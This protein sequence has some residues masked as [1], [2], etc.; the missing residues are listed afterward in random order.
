MMFLHPTLRAFPKRSENPY[1]A[2][3][4]TLRWASEAP[5]RVHASVGKGAGGSRPPL[6]AL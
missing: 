5:P 3:F 4:L 2:D 1:F 6:R